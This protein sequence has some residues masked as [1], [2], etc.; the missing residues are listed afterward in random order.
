MI[1]R[2][3]VGDLEE[4]ARELEL[5]PIA[6]D[7]IQDLDEGV[8]RQILGQLPVADHA[9]DERKDGSLIPADQLTERGIS[10]LLG[11]RDDVGVREVE[12]IEGWR[13]RLG[14]PRRASSCVATGYHKLRGP[15]API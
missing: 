13:H 2:D 6:V 4:P 7:V 11:Q 8:L 1:D 12:K 10:T 15:S 3:V 14:C 9:E 5:G